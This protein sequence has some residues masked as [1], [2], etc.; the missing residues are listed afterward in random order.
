MPPPGAA[1][2][3]TGRRGAGRAPGRARQRDEEEPRDVPDFPEPMTRD[4]PAGCALVE[5]GVTAAPGFRAGSTAAGIK[6]EAGTPDM[7]LL[8]ADAPC[9][10][11]G[12]FT[13]SRAP[14][15]T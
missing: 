1:R 3:P 2:H 5:G 12:T 14:S 11:V 8:V 10:T 4:L 13:T 7:A 6:S 9:V 15:H